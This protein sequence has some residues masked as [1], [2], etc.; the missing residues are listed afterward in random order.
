MLRL[1]KWL[2]VGNIWWQ[3]SS[4]NTWFWAFV[5]SITWPMWARDS[6]EW[7]ERT[8][9]DIR[10]LFTAAYEVISEFFMNSS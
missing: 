6:W 7:V 10:D 5:V 8:A 9:P 4:L 3:L 1:V 2:F